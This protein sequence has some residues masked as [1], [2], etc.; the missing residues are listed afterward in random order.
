MKPGRVV[1]AFLAATLAA[2]VLP[3]RALADAD[4]VL[5][6]VGG[7][8]TARAG[9]TIDV[10]VTVDLSGAPGRQLGSYTAQFTWNPNV[11]LL[12][13]INNGT[14]APPQVNG[15]ASDSG[16]LQLTAAQPAGAGGVVTVF[17]VRFYVLSDSAPSS[18]TVS[19]SEMSATSTSVTP[20]EVL[21]PLLRY[22]QGTFCRSL[23]HWGDV[24]GDGQANSLDALV[25]LSVVVGIPVDTTVMKP[26]LAD[27]DGD[28]QVTSRD[29]LIILSAAVGLPVTGYR[30]LLPAAGGCATGAATTL[31]VTPDSIELEAGQGVAVVVQATDASGRAVPTDIV[32]WTSS[33]PAVAGYDPAKGAV[34]ARS[35]GIAT[36]TAQLGPGV[37]GT[38]KVSVLARRTTWYVD[39]QRALNAP[40]QVGAQAWPFQ[41][42]GDAAAIAQ[43]GDTVLV[44][45]GTYEEIVSTGTAVTVL[46][47]STNRPVIDPRG[48]PYNWFPYDNAFYVGASGAP[49]VLANFVVRAGSVYLSGLGVSV[50]NVAIEG[51]SGTS[52]TALEISSSYN[53]SAPAN[54]GNVLVSNVAVTADSVNSGIL[55]DLADTATIVNSSAIRSVPGGAVEG[56][57]GYGGY[58]GGGI[59]IQQASVSLLSGNTVI[60]PA[61]QGIGVFDY[62]SVFVTSDLGRA[63]ITGNRV[64][65]APGMGIAVGTRE[66]A[67]GHN[68]VKNVGSPGSGNTGAGIYVFDD[69]LAPDTVTSL[70]DTIQNSSARGFVIDTAT[71]AVLDS[72][73]VDSVGQNGYGGDFGVQ[74]KSGGRYALRHSHVSNTL[75]DDAVTA[76]GA[77][78]VLRTNG[79]RITGAG[80]DG[81]SVYNQYGCSGRESNISP[82]TLISTS[83]T[84][85]DSYT[86]AIYVSNAR[87]AVVDSAVVDSAG[88]TSS[89]I[90][91][92]QG[93]WMRVSNSSVRRASYTGI[94]V[95][96]VNHTE[97]LKNSTVADSTNGIYVYGA[98]DSVLVQGNSVDS[99]GAEGIYLDGTINV[100][101]DSTKVTASGAS[102]VSIGFM[103][104]GLITRSRFEGNARY[105]LE[106]PS[107]C[108]NTDSV[109]VRQSAIEGNLLGGIGN[110]D[111]E[112]SES[113]FDAD[114][115]YWG[116]PNGPRCAAFIEGC[117]GL[118]VTGDS[119]T[120]N[121]V[122]FD[123]WLSGAPPT[124]APPFRVLASR[125]A[126]RTASAARPA[127]VTRAAAHASPS[128]RKAQR[129]GGT[130][131]PTAAR[132][133]MV[134]APHVRRIAPAPWHR[135][136]HAAG[137]KISRRH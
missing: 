20:F 108:C 102:G 57:C 93:A 41:F 129:A 31:A 122:L 35:A 88:T 36:L 3:A 94:Y 90:D 64:T 7:D 25:A 66:V 83:D 15:A 55:V 45:S 137:I 49:L 68:A 24:N 91:I 58:T 104:G 2:V 133:A 52:G 37:R 128:A 4:S 107:N 74:F 120:T 8:L 9:D 16:R 42:I 110:F 75:S 87:Y 40:V 81:I 61:C 1:L 30:V 117:S 119:I 100:A 22:V 44:A 17:V 27:V 60:N 121:N 47:D 56:F 65:G 112:M 135:P 97:I 118:S 136:I 38:L 11:L 23:G 126:S 34:Q 51:L 33:N 13:A 12:E 77:H 73:V 62:P 84:I 39:V 26:A 53:E 114:S 72:L 130:A 10:P 127:T 63:T 71:T 96:E 32:T 14:F 69:G 123:A 105:G 103:S 70:G 48:V 54:P 50:R 46:G 80:W 131:T 115:N 6:R 92:E 98:V 79:N 101:M 86:G 109:V 85:T 113:I 67:L 43:D 29:A 132:P 21:L 78:A 28:G 89:G 19:F 82:D 95:Y 124:P 106:R 111:T 99:S 134:A 5:V 116:D 125:A 59:T 18:V 76:C